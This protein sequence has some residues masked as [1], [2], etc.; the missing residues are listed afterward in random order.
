MKR[1]QFVNNNDSSKNTNL[2][3][4][5]NTLSTNKR[6]QFLDNI[7]PKNETSEQNPNGYCNVDF[8]FQLGSNKCFLYL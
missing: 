6:C 8:I 1:Y 4:E 2:K 3:S 5:T 7:V